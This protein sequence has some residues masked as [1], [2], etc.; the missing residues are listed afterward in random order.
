[1]CFDLES[2]GKIDQSR[3]DFQWVGQKKKI[4]GLREVRTAGGGRVVRAMAE[5]ESNVVS[6][7]IPSPFSRRPFTEKI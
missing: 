2:D 3:F 7:L 1:M 5:D 4:V 6:S